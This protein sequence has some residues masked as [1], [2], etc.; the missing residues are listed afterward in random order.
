MLMICPL[1]DVRAAF[2]QMLMKAVSMVRAHEAPRYMEVESADNDMTVRF[3][4]PFVF[5]MMYFS[6]CVLR[7][8]LCR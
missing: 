1:P 6:H 2:S 5:M 7:V 8:V 4:V 3:V